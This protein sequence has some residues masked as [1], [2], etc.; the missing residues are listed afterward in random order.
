MCAAE[1][2]FNVFS[3]PVPVDYNVD[4]VCGWRA[5]DDSFNPEYFASV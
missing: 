4:F 3:P 5:D 2:L 1:M